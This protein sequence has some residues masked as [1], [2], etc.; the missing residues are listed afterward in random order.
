MNPGLRRAT[1]KAGVVWGGLQAVDGH[2]PPL[3]P[4]AAT[5]P[6]G[7]NEEGEAE[8]TAAVAAAA[9]ALPARLRSLRPLRPAPN[10]RR[11]QAKVAAEAEAILW[12]Q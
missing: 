8:A 5:P 6:G 10:A 7:P 3:G 1:R 2:A 4:T 12:E 11:L 9:G